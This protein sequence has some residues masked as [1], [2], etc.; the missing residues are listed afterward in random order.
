MR[1]VKLCKLLY[2][3]YC[4]W[5]LREKSNANERRIGYPILL[6]VSDDFFNAV[7]AQTE[8]NGRTD[9]VQAYVLFT[10][11]LRVP[12]PTKTSFEFGCDPPIQTGR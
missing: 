3:S 9:V 8:Q 10:L 4:T 5:C 1:W 11:D 6:H 12:D 7:R 2:T